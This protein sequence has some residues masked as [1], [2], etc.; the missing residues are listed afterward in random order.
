MAISPY[1]ARLRARVGTELLLVPSATGI[2]Y[3]PENRVLLVRQRADGLWSTPGGA[4]EPDETPADAVVREVREETGLETQAVRLIGAIG[5]PSFVVRYGNGDCTQYVTIVFECAIIGGTLRADNDE[6][7]EAA[8]FSRDEAE[9]AVTQEWLL[10]LLP[11]LFDRSAA[12][13]F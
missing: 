11:R 4:I 2:M 13:F 1:L 9:R 6:V 10:S 5:G 3:D 8:F 7:S 12:P